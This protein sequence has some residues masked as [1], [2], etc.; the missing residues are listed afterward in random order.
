MMRIVRLV[1]GS[2]QKRLIVLA[3]RLCCYSIEGI[4]LVKSLLLPV[5]VVRNI[6]SWHRV[7][8]HLRLLVP[9]KSPVKNLIRYHRA[10]VDRLVWST[11]GHNAWDHTLKYHDFS[12][13]EDLRRILSRGGGL[14]LLSM[15][16]GP[17]F[18][19]YVL[20]HEGLHPAILAAEVNIPDLDGIPLKR[21]LTK[22]YVFRGTYDGIVAANRSE[23]Q[24]VRMMLAGRPGLILMDGIARRS[25]LTANCLGIRYPIGVFPFKLALIHGFPV[26]MMWFSKMEG[27]GYKL[28][29][30]EIRFNTVEE[31]VAQYGAFLDH[32][33]RADPYLWGYWW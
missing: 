16:Y 5:Y 25:C 7:I 17:G 18:A 22:E 6:G 19:G 1:V 32:M 8:Q 33:V 26:A 3:V 29:I 21:L 31:G 20:H 23:R 27:K 9:E 13:V 10:Q 11:L 24:F 2:L 4:S 15:H 30:R 28:N 14:L 12:S